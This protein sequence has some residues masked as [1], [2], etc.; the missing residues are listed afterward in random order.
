MKFGTAFEQSQQAILDQSKEVV[1]LRANLRTATEA[2][3]EASGEA[4]RL[5]NLRSDRE[6]RLTAAIVKL[7]ELIKGPFR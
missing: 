5:R 2:A 7:D 6:K 3:D 4:T 1:V